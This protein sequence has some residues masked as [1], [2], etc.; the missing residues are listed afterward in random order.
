VDWDALAGG[1]NP[2]QAPQAG[3]SSPPRLGA[4]R[5]RHGPPWEADGP[6]PGSFWATIKEFFTDVS[7]FFSNMRLEGGVGLP[8][9]FM[10]ICTV[11]GAS[12]LAMQQLA[13]ATMGL[14]GGFE[15]P[16]NPPEAVGF[17]VG[18]VL[19]VLCVVGIL[20]PVISFVTAAVYHLMLTLL[21]GAHQGFE[22]TFRVVAYTSAH[23]MLMYLIPCCGN[24]IGGLAS[25]VLAII[26]LAYAHDTSGWRAAGAVLLPMAV[27][28]VGA[29]GLGVALVSLEG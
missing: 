28:C 5:R 18:F 12:F 4:S 27:C 10:M 3:L 25:I 13:L 23:S 9:A 17:M 20:V 14:A 21:G 26:G 19:G 29:V 1:Y 8:L 24:Y 6:S 7:G 16:D 15:L 22:A 11:I 2:Y